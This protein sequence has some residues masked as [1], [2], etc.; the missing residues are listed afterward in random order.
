[1]RH[2]VIIDTDL[3]TCTAVQNCLQTNQLPLDIT[4]FAADGN[5]G[6]DVIRRWNPDVV[7]M[8][9]AA[10][11]VDAAMFIQRFP[12]SRF[13][14]LTDHA[15][16]NNAVYAFRAGAS[17]ILLKPIR[18]EQ[19]LPSLERITYY[20][21]AYSTAVND[22]IELI[23][24]NYREKLTLEDISRFVYLS[25]CH[26]A[27]VFKRQTG[28]TILNYHHYVRIM[29]AKELLST[30]CN[31]TDCAFQVGYSNIN[32]FFKYFKRFTNS[33]PHSFQMKARFGN[34]YDQEIWP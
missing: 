1:M 34:I 26:I 14:L 21:S 5:T 24:H 29:K 30:G 20:S 22:V 18:N 31:I 19:L 4:G 28:K 16:F 15:D 13:I 2:L 27:R 9:M 25:P 8:S 23:C 33:T 3:Y 10:P 12:D 32:Q 17:D 11:G 6:L 7:L